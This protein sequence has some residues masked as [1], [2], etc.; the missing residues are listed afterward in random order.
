MDM[1]TI[2]GYHTLYEWYRSMESEHFPDPTGL[3]ARM[4]QWSF[5]LY[6]ACVKYLMS[7]FDIPEVIAPSSFM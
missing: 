6:P 1:Q 4:E 3:R 5:G 2:S 7:S